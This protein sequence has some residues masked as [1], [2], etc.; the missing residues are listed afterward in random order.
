M[1]RSTLRAS[2]SVTRTDG[3]SVVGGP[4]TVPSSDTG[5]SRHSRLPEVHGRAFVDHNRGRVRKMKAH[6][7]VFGNTQRRQATRGFPC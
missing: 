4:R 2:A 3:W 6:C 5:E 1:P 7:D